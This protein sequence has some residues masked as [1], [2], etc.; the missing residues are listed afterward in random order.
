MLV[1]D[2]NYPRD[3][4]YLGM[5][6]ARFWASRGDILRDMGALFEQFGFEYSDQEVG[7][8]GSVHLYIATKTVSTN[9]H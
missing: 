3:R 6:L 7:G 5:K 1:V 2:V 8:F 9:L 4:D